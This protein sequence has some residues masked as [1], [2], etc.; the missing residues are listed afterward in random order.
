MWQGRVLKINAASSF[1][2]HIQEVV[3]LTVATRSPNIPFPVHRKIMGGAADLPQRSSSPLKRRASDL[4]Q[5]ELKPLSRDVEMTMATEDIVAEAEEKDLHSSRP[6]EHPPV[7]EQIEKVTKMLE[8]VEAVPIKDGDTTFL[9]SNAWLARVQARATG[10]KAT[11]QDL[12]GDV[13]PIDN[14]DIIE[15]ILTDV[16]GKPFARLKPDITPDSYKFFPLGAWRYITEL[17]GLAEGQI[18]VIRFAKDTNSNSDGRVNIQYELNPPIFKIH[19]LWSATSPIPLPQL[20]KASSPEAPVFVMS[21]GDLFVDMLKHAKKKASIEATSKIRLWRLNKFLPSGPQP[22]VK[23]VQSSPPLSRANTPTP[24]VQTPSPWSKLLVEV[25]EFTSL[26][27]GVDREFIDQE[28]V[29]A[30]PKYNGRS[31]TIDIAGLGAD[32]ELVID[33]HIERESFVSNFSATAVTTS[34]PI[35]GFRPVVTKSQANSGRN[36]PTLV[37]PVTRGRTQKSGRTLGSVGLSN[38]GNTCYMNSALQCV[39]SVEELT[40]Y[41]LTDEWDAE[42]N[43]DNPL[44][45]NGN[46]AIQYG[47]LLKEFYRENASTVTPRQFKNT[48]GRY[49]PSFSGYGQ[50]DSQEF[51]GFLLDGLQEDLSRIKKKP[52]IEKPDSTDEMVGDQEAIARMADQVWDITKKRDDSVIADLFTGMYKSTL[53]CPECSKVSI[54]FDPFN[55][56]TLQLPIESIWHHNVIYIPINGRPVRISVELDKQASIKALKQFIGKRVGVSAERLFIAE[57]WKHKFY[58]FFE[59]LK[60]ASEEITQN[61]EILVYELEAPPTNTSPK[62][63]K[64]ARHRS[65]LD[66]IDD[67]I[68]PNWA[69]PMSAR[70]LVPVIHRKPAVNSRNFRSTPWELA[71]IPHFII[72]TPDEARSED[73]IRRKVLE[74]VAGF[75]TYPALH[76]DVVND[77]SGDGT[78]PDLVVTTA[79]D[80]DSSGDGKVS[81]MSVDGED[82]VVD[83]SMKESGNVQDANRVS[84]TPAENFE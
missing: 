9:V 53:V 62:K 28:D 43:V 39:R 51:L 76:E 27:K 22:S 61:D 32:Q 10:A 57:A 41:F 31:L 46:V 75:T 3:K 4:E 49:A 83:V 69:D 23:S 13:G 26:E 2:Q 45:N 58:R 6:R 67:E 40:K 44:G 81:A 84:N 25:T 7:D 24:E 54:T 37:G 73:M 65:M 70:M 34:I 82:D 71:P 19:R 63:V 77:D 52:Y 15:D 5:D 68:I 66:P 1:A 30:N 11:L 35:A 42:L 79:S 50:Q 16:N 55:N 8:A 72:V 47:Q 14:S 78:D 18:P 64:P 80:A 38:L 29:S 59:D 60:P 20:L 56:L 74:M 17:Y 36:S 33:E 12:E 48:I 21:R